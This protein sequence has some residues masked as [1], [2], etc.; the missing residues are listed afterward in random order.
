MLTRVSPGRDRRDALISHPR[1]MCRDWRGLP[2]DL[3]ETAALADVVTVS[4]LTDP[5]AGVGE[6]SLREAFPDL[7][8]VDAQH[9][10]ADLVTFWPTRDHRRAVRA[11]L[12]V[13]DVDI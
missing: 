13:V 4:A 10:V 11:A 7:V 6:A 9:Y 1:L 8:R 12:Q 5:L 3:V 2:D